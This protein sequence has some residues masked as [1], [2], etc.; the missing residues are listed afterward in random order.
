MMAAG[1]T[2][3][4]RYRLDGGGRANNGSPLLTAWIFI[5]IKPVRWVIA[6]V[7][8][9]YRQLVFFM[10]DAFIIIALLYWHP[11]CVYLGVDAFGDSRFEPT[12]HRPK[13]QA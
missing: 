3:V 4:R 1:R 11:S 12:D 7:L 2:T 6:D 8:A 5:V 9:H 10:N 13:D